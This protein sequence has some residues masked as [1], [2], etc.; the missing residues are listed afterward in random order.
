[1]NFVSILIVADI[2]II[3]LLVFFI[4]I[5]SI[6]K[7]D[8][9]EE[10]EK[11]VVLNKGI[12]ADERVGIRIDKIR[13]YLS[14]N[15]VAENIGIKS[16]E[17]YIIV[18]LILLVTFFIIGLVVF[19]GISCIFLGIV[20]FY[21]LNIFIW[22]CNDQ[23][24]EKMIRDLKS[25]YDTLR[26]Q[27]KA[28]VFLSD[29]LRECYLVVSNKRLKNA[30]YQLNKDIMLKHDIEGAIEQLS[31][32]FN[33]IYIE[34]FVLTIKQSIKT[35]QT[36]DMLDDISEQMRE[37]EELIHSQEKKRLETKLGI[38][39]VLVLIGAM[40]MSMYFVFSELDISSFMNM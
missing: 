11:L 27:L 10:I 40:V 39:Q 35:G 3:A 32:Q 4:S 23:D 21:I 24:N 20:G 36:V 28:G 26:I 12:A 18:K 16:V 13:L 5:I 33:N 25:V 19:G 29:A 2:C 34:D 1:M 30:F 14:K 22:I 8:S 17:Q 31:T 37:A 7:A 9:K 6:K 15:G 38:I